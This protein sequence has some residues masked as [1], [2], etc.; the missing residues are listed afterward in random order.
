MACM[1]R[2]KSGG[3]GEKELTFLYRLASGASPESYGL[4]VATMAGI[5]M[6]IVQKASVAGQMMKSKIARNFKSSEGR[7][8]FSTLHEDWLRTI[9]A[10]GGV[11][12]AH[13]DED[14]MDTAFCVAQELKSHF[15]KGGR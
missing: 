3:N 12:D 1:L 8:E 7:A 14:T 10:I 4:Q 11:K 5:P 6:S 15:R 13:L 9:L 2:P